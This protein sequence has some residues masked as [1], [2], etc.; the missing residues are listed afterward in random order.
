V[1]SVQ[2]PHRARLLIVDDDRWIV[3]MVAEAFTD[4]GFEVVTAQDGGA[5][6][7]LIETAP[8]DVVLLDIT[9]PGMSGLEVLQH[10]SLRRPELPVVMLSGNDH[11]ELAKRTLR[12]GAFDYVA[13]PFNFEHLRQCVDAALLA[14]Q[15]SVPP[16]RNPSALIITAIRHTDLCQECIAH[17][18][19]LRHVEVMLKLAEM[20]AAVK[21]MVH[22]GPCG[23]CQR[24]TTLYR[25][26]AG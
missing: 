7:A 23:S 16:S 10:L 8:P 1:P 22:E 25:V 15:P 19:G 4:S 17:T 14:R 21:M 26:S 5:A 12:Q 9:M 20:S 18:T 24:V 13:K 11:E 3:E 2:T 6:L